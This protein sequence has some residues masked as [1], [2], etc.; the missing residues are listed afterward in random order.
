MRLVAITNTETQITY[1]VYENRV[2]LAAYV[3]DKP[4][5][6]PADEVEE[7]RV[8]SYAEKA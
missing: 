4:D 2:A 5:F 1:T 8:A 6:L 3:I 7:L